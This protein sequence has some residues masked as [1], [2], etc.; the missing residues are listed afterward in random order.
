MVTLGREK[1]WWEIHHERSV[2]AKLGSGLTNRF[3]YGHCHCGQSV[4]HT[5]GNYGLL[6]CVHPELYVFADPHFNM[7]RLV[8]GTSS[9]ARVIFLPQLQLNQS[10]KNL[11][12]SI[13]STGIGNDV[14][15][16]HDFF[17]H[18]SPCTQ[19]NEQTVQYQTFLGKLS[20]AD[21]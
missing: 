11:C 8:A 1:K 2:K 15:F 7:L 13:I 9:V 3:I 19:T 14:P 5:L 4:W 18:W 17:H 21:R 12:S 20:A 10:L 16:V 6:F